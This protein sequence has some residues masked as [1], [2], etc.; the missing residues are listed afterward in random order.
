MRRILYDLATAYAAASGCGCEVEEGGS[1]AELSVEGL[2][3]HIGLVEESDMMLFQTAVAVLPSEEAGRG[4]CCR[5]LLAA[6]NL[7]VGTLGFTLGVDEE[8][9]IVTLQIAWDA[10]RLDAEGFGR[11]VNNLLSVALDWMLRLDDW[12]PSPPAR[13]G[14]ASDEPLPMHF[15]KV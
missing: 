1:R 3:V 5:Q 12:R 7:F 2:S 11:I 6:N 10:L 4:E 13:E 15:L 8:T 9:Q 14:E